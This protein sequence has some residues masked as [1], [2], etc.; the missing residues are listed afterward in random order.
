MNSSGGTYQ[1]RDMMSRDERARRFGIDCI[2]AV[3]FVDWEPGGEYRKKIVLKNVLHRAQSVKFVSPKSTLFSL[4]FPAPVH[5]SSGL[6]TS[7]EVT[8]RPL[9]AVYGETSVEIETKQGSFHIPIVAEIPR[10]DVD[11][12]DTVDFGFCPVGEPTL[13][14]LYIAN[15]G[16]LPAKYSIECAAP[17]SVSPAQGITAPGQQI[18]ISVSFLPPQAIVLAGTVVVHVEG[19]P[20]RTIRLTGIGKF[21]HLAVARISGTTSAAMS[22]ARMQGTSDDLVS[23]F[24]FSGCASDKTHT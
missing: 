13:K 2:D 1:L 6:A 23:S 3:V 4:P 22:A 16:Q 10:R 8:F 21:P 5:L 7:I 18:E 17:F 14:S 19:L 24:G 15:T 9:E 12:P 11:I 20:T